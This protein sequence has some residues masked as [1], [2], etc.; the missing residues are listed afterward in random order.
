[1]LFMPFEIVLSQP[2]L[3][4]SRLGGVKNYGREKTVAVPGFPGFPGSFRNGTRKHLIV[5][6]GC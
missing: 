2:R 3:R 6:K 4:M 5:Q 1:M